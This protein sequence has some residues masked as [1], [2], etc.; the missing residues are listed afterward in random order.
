METIRIDTVI[1]DDGY[2][3]IDIPTPLKEGE[4]EVILVIQKKEPHVSEYDFS[5]IAGKLQW[6]GN[7]E[8]M[9]RALRNEWK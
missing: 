7:A 2:L 1:K 4:V 8:E 9:Q 6:N 5:D 3:K